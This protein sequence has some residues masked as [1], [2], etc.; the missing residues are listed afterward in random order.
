VSGLSRRKFIKSSA[1]AGAG[2]FLASNTMLAAP[3]LLLKSKVNKNSSLG[4]IVFVPHYV[5][6]GRG[7]HL[8]ELAWATDKEWEP[9][10]SNI[11]MDSKGVS[12][13]D[14]KN[15]DKFGINVRW[16]VEGFGWTNI[17]ADNGGEFYSLPSSGKSQSL[18]L[19]YELCKSRVVRN[20]HRLSDLKKSGWIPSTEVMMYV[21]LSE[22]FYEDARQK[23]NDDFNSANFAQSGLMYALWASEKMEVEKAKFDIVLRGKRDDFFF[24]C[25]ARSFY[26]M[27]QDTFLDLFSEVFNY[28]NIT[29]VAKGDGIMSDYQTAPGVIQPETRELLIKKLNERGIK[30]QERLL[31][32]FH[33]CCIPDWLRDMKYDDLLKYAEKLT[34]DTMKHFGDMLYA[35]EIVNEL[36]DWAN[37]LQLSPE[38][39]TELTRLINDVAKSVAPNVKRTINNCCPYAEYVQMNSYSKK[40]AVFPQRSPFKFT[41][42][43]IDAGIDFDILEQQMYYPYRDLQDSIL[44]LE[45]LSTLGKPMQLSEVGV[46]GGPSNYSVR[47]STVPFSKEP[48]LWHKPWNEHTQADWLEDIYTLAFSKPF[49]HASNWFDFVDPYYFMEN[50]GLLQSP[51]GEKKE[52]YHRLK[53]IR[54]NWDQ[55]PRK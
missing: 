6:K 34:K 27:Y 49:I 14:S 9:F 8:Y 43:I 48:Y 20:R 7:P 19:N 13:S 30:S 35:M 25:D 52:A 21:N 44:L 17:T 2:T 36:H 28:A 26:Q 29:F 1:I 47:N 54:N 15:I 33:D 12:I 46:P 4:E 24:G 53:K 55:L 40:K 5:Q 39:I 22:Q 51:K 31:F 3:E 32:W 10:L 42:D 37:E 41:K 23:I 38:Q 50:G 45:K 11:K 18:N 16:N